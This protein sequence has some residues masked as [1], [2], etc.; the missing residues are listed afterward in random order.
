MQIIGANGKITKNGAIVI[1][2][3]VLVVLITVILA[4]CLPNSDKNQAVLESI[5]VSRQP[6]KTEYIVGETLDING[7]EITAIYNNGNT[8]VITSYTFDKTQPL[9]LND[10][11]VTISYTENGVTKTTSYT[12][13]VEN[14]IL[15]SLEIVSVPLKSE[16]FVGEY[17][18]FLGLSVKANYTNYESGIVS[19]WTYDKTEPLTLE[20]GVVTVSY[21]SFGI[22]KTANIEI[23]VTNP[24]NIEKEIAEIQNIL[25]FIPPP[26]ELN[27]DNLDA[28]QYLLDLYDELTPEQ[29]ELL[30]NAEQYEALREKID[31]II[32]AQAELPPLPESIYVVQYSLYGN[33]NF[34]DIDFGGNIAEYKNSMEAISLNSV[35]SI[36]AE[37]QGYEFKYWIDGYGNTITEVQNLASDMTYYAVFGLTDTVRIVYKD[38]NNQVAVLFSEEVARL[39]NNDYNYKL[40]LTL[41]NLMI[42]AYYDNDGRTDYISLESRAEIVVFVVAVEY[43]EITVE[44]AADLIVSW[45]Y[46]HTN[47]G[48]ETI[49]AASGALVTDS[50]I[51]PIGASL[52]VS[53]NGLQVN[54]IFV[55]GASVAKRNGNFIANCVIII[56]SSEEPLAITVTRVFNELTT[57]SL[58]GLNNKSYVFPSGWNGKFTANELYDISVIFGEDDENYLNI[59][60][61]GNDELLFRDL[62]DYTFTADTAVI[63]THRLNKFVITIRYNGGSV[64]VGGLIGKQSLQ[65]ALFGKTGENI[66]T[67]N[68]LLANENIFSDVELQNTITADEVLETYIIDNIELFSS[69]SGFPKPTIEEL[70]GEAQYENQSFI[71][72]WS[73]IFSKDN[74]IYNIELIL[75]GDGTYSYAAKINGVIVAEIDGVYRYENGEISIKILILSGEYPTLIGAEEFVVNIDYAV[76]GLLTVPFFK[77]IGTKIIKFTATLTKGNVRPVNYTGKNFIETYKTSK[78]DGNITRTLEIT[79]NENGTINIFAQIIEN[80]CVVFETL[81]NGYYRVVDGN[82]FLFSNGVLGTRNI[83]DLL[84]LN[85]GIAI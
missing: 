73:A 32:E 84:G 3:G 4:I 50:L 80:E 36:I 47:D 57:I 55:N 76:D 2:V 9:D 42:I 23:T 35:V 41:E 10:T 11:S 51:V 65:N 31:E 54:E 70:Y 29:K 83:S 7:L 19:G 75:N 34:A 85:G 68:Y 45:E 59:Y 53:A 33:L 48:G 52:S 64:A 44:S 26:E 66:E 77:V 78:T 5:K 46:S 43:R 21:A 58:Y 60:N 1:S 79:L 56:E 12:I 82:V 16:Y 74:M 71:G 69:F 6:Y 81:E 27:E 67:F 18:D 22:T 8:A 49:T 20:D 63:V 72:S 17:F 39:S 28:V 15:D 38:Y 61:I 13:V 24:Q 25:E 14:K 62:E 30:Q 40:N 37:E